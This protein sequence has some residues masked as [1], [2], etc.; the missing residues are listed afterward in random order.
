MD[1][2]RN[3]VNS[4]SFSWNKKFVC[5]GVR[6]IQ[7][8]TE[9]QLALMLTYINANYIITEICI[10]MIYKQNIKGHNVLDKYFVSSSI[11]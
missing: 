5:T 6:F 7:K 4:L 11:V 9:V 8:E 3:E 2:D 10:Q 1:L